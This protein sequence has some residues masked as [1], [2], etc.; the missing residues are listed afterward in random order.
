MWSRGRIQSRTKAKLY[1]YIFKKK[2]KKK[3]SFL[4]LTHCHSD[5]ERMR[6]QQDNSFNATGYRNHKRN[7]SGFNSVLIWNTQSA[8][9]LTAHTA[10]FSFLSNRTNSMTT[11]RTSLLSLGS[12]FTLWNIH[13]IKSCAMLWMA[14]TDRHY[15]AALFRSGLH[16]KKKNGSW[17][18]E[19]LS[20]SSAPTILISVWKSWHG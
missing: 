6:N 7:D 15:S 4:P 12:G 14:Q 13:G 3:V 10:S 20:L 16:V 17:D 19:T 9:V 18:L 2:E 5:A 1:I 8:S 11:E